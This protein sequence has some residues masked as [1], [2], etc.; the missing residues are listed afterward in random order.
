MDYVDQKEKE[1][2][3]VQETIDTE[4]INSQTNSQVIIELQKQNNFKS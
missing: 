3:S 1:L 2:L 4:K